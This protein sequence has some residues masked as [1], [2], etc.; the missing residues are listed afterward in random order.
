M[1]SIRSTVTL[2][3]VAGIVIAMLAAGAA[4]AVPVETDPQLASPAQLDLEMS[5]SS[6][7]RAPSMT[8]AAPADAVLREAL[9]LLQG[10]GTIGKV[11][12]VT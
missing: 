9:R 6:L 10:G 7:L 8:L 2:A 12:L 4:V 3:S 11:V 5:E 1:K